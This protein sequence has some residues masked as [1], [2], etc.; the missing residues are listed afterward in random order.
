MNNWKIL[1]LVGE[2]R[3][4]IVARVTDVLYRDGWNLGE[5]SMIRLGS[6]FTIMMMIS[7]QGDPVSLLQPVA[8]ELGLRLHVDPSSGGLHQ[9][10]V[11][12]IQVRV[13]GADRAGIVAQVTAILAAAGFNIL[14]LESDVAGSAKSPVYIMNIQGITDATVESLEQALQGLDEQGVEVQ[15]SAIETLIG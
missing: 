2:D 5:A 1:T 12:N 7:G 8:D 10:I 13:V 6:N 3:P 11:P 4:G 14:E 15:V 9:H